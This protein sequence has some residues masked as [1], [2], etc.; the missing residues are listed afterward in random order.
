MYTTFLRDGA[1][2]CS[3]PAVLDALLPK[4]RAFRRTSTASTLTGSCP[5]NWK[6]LPLQFPACE[7]TFSGV[8]P[9]LFSKART[10]LSSTTIPYCAKASWMLSCRHF[11]FLSLSSSYGVKCILP[12]SSPGELCWEVHGTLCLEVATISKC[13]CCND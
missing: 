11:F 4:F 7:T 12:S 8:L 6:R 5:A 10:T 3:F 2:V 13:Q 9:C 1:C